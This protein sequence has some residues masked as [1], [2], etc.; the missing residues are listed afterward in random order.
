MTGECSPSG[1]SLKFI[2]QSC[3]LHHSLVI[4]ESQN[5]IKNNSQAHFDKLANF[6]LN[7]DASNFEL[8]L[9]E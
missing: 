8:K 5:L 7:L 6:Y 1:E 2:S 3:Q 9:R 4:K